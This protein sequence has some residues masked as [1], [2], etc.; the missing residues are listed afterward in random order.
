MVIHGIYRAKRLARFGLH[1]HGL[2]TITMRSCLPVL[3]V[4]GRVSARLAGQTVVRWHPRSLVDVGRAASY[5]TVSLQGPVNGV[6]KRLVEAVGGR[7]SYSVAPSHS[8]TG[9]HTRSDVEVGVLDWYVP[10]EH[11]LTAL[12]NVSVDSVA[13]TTWNVAPSTHSLTSVQIRFAETLEGNEEKV[14][15]SAH[16]DSA[17]H[18]AM[19]HTSE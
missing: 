19:F 10:G 12:Q 2:I 5:S 9:A 15:P 14:T 17:L 4:G 8:R 7:V 16:D 6:H 1:T 11:T 13:G 18:V 3:F